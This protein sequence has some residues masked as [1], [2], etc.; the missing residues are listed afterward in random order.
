MRLLLGA[1]MIALA[2]A[3]A[4]NLPEANPQRRPTRRPQDGRAVSYRGVADFRAGG[5]PLA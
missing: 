3:A 2:I 4:L 1:L 5:H